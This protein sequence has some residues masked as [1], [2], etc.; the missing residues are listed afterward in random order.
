MAKTFLKWAGGKTRYVDALFDCQPAT[1][2]SRLVEPFA[3]SAA[4]FFYLEPE[5]AFLADMNE[6]LIVCFREVARDPQAIIEALDQM[7]NNKEF[8]L[9]VRAQDPESL[10][11]TQRAARVI[12]LNKTCFRGLWRVNRQGKFNVPYGNYDR[13]LYSRAVLERA[14]ELLQRAKLE[15]M[16]CEAVLAKT[17]KTDWVYLDPPY[18][19]AGG[20]SDF[21]RFTAQQFNLPDHERLVD[22]LHALSARGV[23]FLLT[24]TNNQEARELYEG[25]RLYQLETKRDIALQADRRKSTDLVVANYEITPNPYVIP[26]GTDGF[27]L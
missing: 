8:F 12:Y 9:G 22:E 2:Y 20:Y 4:L 26:I 17:R 18:I 1:G 16:P 19:P 25:F 5:R 23:P 24:N 6:E 13:P 15:Y 21:K 11:P 27:A 7:P 10:S 3:G 14:S